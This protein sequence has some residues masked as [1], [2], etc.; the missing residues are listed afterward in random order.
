MTF[1]TVHFSFHKTTKR[2]LPH[3]LWK[4]SPC[5]IIYRKSVRWSSIAQI[6]HFLDV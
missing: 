2:I 5:Y 4:D 3:I 6:L 1:I